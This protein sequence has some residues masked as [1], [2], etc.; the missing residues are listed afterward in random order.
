[1]DKGSIETAA[2]ILLEARQ[3]H[4]HAA[5]LPDPCRPSNS[6][7]AYEIQD[8][9]SKTL[10]SAVIGWKVGATNA[11]AQETL[12]TDAP[13]SG[14]MLDSIT[15]DSPVSLQFNDFFSPGIEVEMAF[16]LGKNLSSGKKDSSSKPPLQKPTYKYVKKLHKNNIVFQKRSA[17]LIPRR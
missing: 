12:G 7:E 10:G 16:R 1:M 13:F 4:S 9:L 6:A 8:H 17:S 14:R 3:N 5:L 11:K 15:F 2:R